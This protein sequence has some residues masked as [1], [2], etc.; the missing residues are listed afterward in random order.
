MLLGQHGG[1]AV[2]SGSGSEWMD[3]VTCDV[4]R[5]WM[6]I[7]HFLDLKVIHV[8]YTFRQKTGVD[9]RWNDPVGY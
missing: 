3:G 1:V 2:V 9:L 7:W 5:S 4:H 6:K 8:F